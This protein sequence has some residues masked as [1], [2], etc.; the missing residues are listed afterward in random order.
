M[1]EVKWSLKFTVSHFLGNIRVFLEH[2]QL[3]TRSKPLYSAARPYDGMR[4][5]IPLS[6]IAHHP[7]NHYDCDTHKG[8]FKVHLA[9]FKK[10]AVIELSCLTISTKPTFQ[11][12]ASEFKL[13][14][15]CSWNAWK[16]T[17]IL[18]IRAMRRNS[19]LVVF[20]LCSAKDIFKISE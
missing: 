13:P 7:S 5:C 15:Q 4:I 14:R 12:P 17:R 16:R 18:D 11:F 20:H 9:A 10:F 8:L 6:L 2:K 1:Y 19:M 3:S